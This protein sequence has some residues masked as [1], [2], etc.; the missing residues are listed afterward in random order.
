MIHARFGKSIKTE[1][2]AGGCLFVTQSDTYAA[3]LGEPLVVIAIDLR[4]FVVEGTAASHGSDGHTFVRK[5]EARFLSL[6]P[7]KTVPP[8]HDPL[9]HRES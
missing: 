9:T 4:V 5:N 6:D 3:K 2:W 1:E 7:N 8:V